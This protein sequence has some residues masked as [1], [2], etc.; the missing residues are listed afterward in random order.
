M[1]ALDAIKDKLYPAGGADEGEAAANNVGEGA[2]ATNPQ[3]G[4]RLIYRN[5]QWQPL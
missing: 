1:S 3:T 2:T 5:G 4:E